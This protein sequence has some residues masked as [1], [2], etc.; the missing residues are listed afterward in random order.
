MNQVK[1][2]T[3]AAKVLGISRKTIHRYL[4]QGLISQDARGN[5]NLLEIKKVLNSCPP[6]R[7]STPR[8]DFR[9]GRKSFHETTRQNQWAMNKRAAM[10]RE[11]AA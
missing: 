5:L 2:K 9:P 6:S 8:K 4:A 3:K 7:P 11:A 10:K 1:T